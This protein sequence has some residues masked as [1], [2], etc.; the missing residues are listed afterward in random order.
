MKSDGTM[1]LLKGLFILGLV[2]T[3][4]VIAF[5]WDDGP[6]VRVPLTVTAEQVQAR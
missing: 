4:L 1:A 2:W 3:A 6:S 5:G